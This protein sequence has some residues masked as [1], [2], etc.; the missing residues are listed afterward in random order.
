MWVCVFIVLICQVETNKSVNI[1]KVQGMNAFK[2]E[3]TMDTSC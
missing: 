2:Q 3:K 1:L